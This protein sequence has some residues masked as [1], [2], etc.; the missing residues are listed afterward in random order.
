MARTRVWRDGRVVAEN[1]PVAE[2][3]DWLEQR[4][5]L[6]W[7]D[8][9]RPTAEDLAA[10][11]EELQLHPLAVED[12]VNRHQR[13]KLDRYETHQFLSAYQ[14]RFEQ[15]TGVLTAAEVSVFLT[16]AAIVTV[17]STPEFDIDAVVRRWDEE[18]PPTAGGE[19]PHQGV[20]HLLHAVLDH[21]V[22]SHFT[23][24]QEMDEQLEGVEDMLFDDRPRERE[25]QRR[26]FEMRKSL[27][28]L[29][30]LALP[31]REV[32][33][34]LMRR[35]DEVV[36]PELLPYYQ[37]IYDHV[38]RV[39]EW[40][41]SL[42]DLISTVLDTNLTIQGNRLNTIMKQ[43]TSWAAVIAVPTAVTGF[44]G[45]NVPYPGFGH[46]SGFIASTTLTVGVSVALILV[47]RRR[48]WI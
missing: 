2:V 47:F 40:T 26:S 46:W 39:T 43:L 35:D 30:K 44:Y 29:R 11:A 10:I 36:S 41:E 28:A 25:V 20:G 33:N 24:V 22:D 5:T 6:V 15:G 3:S 16:R 7:L 32:V 19:T 38:L 17:R 45:Q 21:V 8:M 31:M 23:A 34:G 48:G 42:R 37:D 27:V 14:V 13:P 12:A 1:I 18:A 4:G 9:C